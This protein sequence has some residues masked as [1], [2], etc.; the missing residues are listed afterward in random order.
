MNFLSQMFLQPFPFGCDIINEA[1]IKYEAMSVLFSRASVTAD[2]ELRAKLEK[3]K[4]SA[5]TGKSIRLASG[6]LKIATL[7]DTF[8]HA[9]LVKVRLVKITLLN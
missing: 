7:H 5:D 4:V 3:W 8:I 6:S 9:P 1:F 2:T